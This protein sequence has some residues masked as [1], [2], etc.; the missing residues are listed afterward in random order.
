MTATAPIL[1][2]AI[3]DGVLVPVKRF[4]REAMKRY[5]AGQTYLIETREERSLA[6]HGHFFASLHECWQNLPENEAERFPSVERLRKWCLIKSGYADERQIVC[7]SK[8]EA[9]RV[10]A[11]IRPMDEYAIVLASEAVVTVY[12]AKSQSMRAM[13]KKDFGESKDAVLSLA[14]SLVGMQPEEA[15]PHIGRA[16]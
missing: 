4:Q 11:F 10:A 5:E 2:E 12:T 3:E 7:A 16:A 1:F 9:Q 13:G 15:A 14:W 8:A 6:S